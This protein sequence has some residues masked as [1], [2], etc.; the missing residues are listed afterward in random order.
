IVAMPAGQRSAGQTR[1]LRAYFLEQAAPEPIRA[2]YQRLAL[3]REQR[4]RLIDGFPTTMVM[5]EMPKPRDTF[6]LNRGVYDRPGEKVSPGVPA[7]L[8][9]L[10]ADIKNDRLS[11]ARW[12]IS[13]ENPLTARVA[14]NRYWQLFFGTGL[15]KT[16]EDFGTQGEW[17]SH[18]E[19]L[20]WLAV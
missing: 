20:D 9:R 3:L 7:T 11:F 14:V 19:L 6:V 4:E 1:K 12:L 10:A 15:V 2:V 18:P 16:V 5:K 13:P 17:P 8:P